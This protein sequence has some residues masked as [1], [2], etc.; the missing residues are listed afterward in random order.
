MILT[1]SFI[2]LAEVWN[3][4]G[5]VLFKKSTNALNF[6]H[7][8]GVK[9]Y[10]H[11]LVQVVR[12]PGIALGLLAMTGGLVFWLAALSRSELSI[13]FPLG[14]LQYIL[15]LFASRLFLGEENNAMRVL[16]NLFIAAGIAF[17]ALNG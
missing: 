7:G 4:V 10:V 12:Q 14:S 13:V 8:K 16:G 15:I 3:T 9:S 5:Q 11:F 1:I 2:L 6:N 17:I